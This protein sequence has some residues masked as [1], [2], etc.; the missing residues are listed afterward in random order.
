ME[1]PF[2]MIL[3]WHHEAFGVM[4]NPD[5]D[6]RNFLSHPHTNNGFNFCPPLNSAFD[7]Y[8]REG[9]KMLNYKMASL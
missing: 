5:P 1:K 3:V 4:T 9:T 8:V 2:T 6:G 7:S